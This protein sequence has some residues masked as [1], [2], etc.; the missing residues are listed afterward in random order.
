M[1]LKAL[2]VILFLSQLS[3]AQDT[4]VM[5]DHQIIIAKLS[6]ITPTQIKYKRFD[7]LNGPDYVV[8]KSQ[9]KLVK[10]ANGSMDVFPDITAPPK[11]VET[12]LS[13]KIENADRRK[14]LYQNKIIGV[15]RMYKIVLNENNTQLN[16]LVKKAKT[17]RWLCYVNYGAI[18]GAVLAIGSISNMNNSS[19]FPAPYNQIYYEESKNE[20]IAFSVFG[21]VCGAVGVTFTITYKKLNKKIVA[22]YNQKH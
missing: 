21:V 15:N 8:E 17:A 19:R 20:A 2:L 22:L 9:V 13:K 3:P 11:P 12:T 10:Y 5:H 16:K 1:K 14:Y 18:G 4:I 6:E 7:M